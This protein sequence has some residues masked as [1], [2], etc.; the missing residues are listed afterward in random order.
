M[1]YKSPSIISHEYS[2]NPKAFNC[3][4]CGLLG[5]YYHAETRM[6]VMRGGFMMLSPDFRNF[7]FRC[8]WDKNRRDELEIVPGCCK[9]G[10]ELPEDRTARLKR[11]W[12]VKSS[13]YSGQ[14]F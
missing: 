9:D 8:K 5:P 10:C 2:K 11:A 1:S 13:D 12:G 6:Y 7:E 14:F 4:N 3:K